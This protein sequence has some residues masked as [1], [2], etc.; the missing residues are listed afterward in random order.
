MH[1]WRKRV[2]FWYIF[3][4]DTIRVYSF[5]YSLTYGCEVQT[6][7]LGEM[8]RFKVIEGHHSYILFLSLTLSFGV[9]SYIQDCEIWPRGA[10]Q[11]GICRGGSQGTS[12]SLDLIFPLTGLSENFPA[13]ERMIPRHC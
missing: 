1:H 4:A 12:P 13:R 11:G 6:A 10:E 5:R 7:A 9:N 2:S 8:T 3:V